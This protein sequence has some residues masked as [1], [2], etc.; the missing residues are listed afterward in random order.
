MWFLLFS[1]NLEQCQNSFQTVFVSSRRYTALHSAENQAQYS[2]HKKKQ[3]SL[4]FKGYLFFRCLF[5]SYVKLVTDYSWWRFQRPRSLSPFYFQNQ[6]SLPWV[7]EHPDVFNDAAFTIT[8]ADKLEPSSPI[9][10]SVPMSSDNN[11]D[12]L[13]C[14]SKPSFHSL[15]IQPSILAQRL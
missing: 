10:V 14:A 5:W 13:C 9:T 12:Q 6:V 4:C 11:Y 3:V 15:R 1:V 8:A 2:S 7:E